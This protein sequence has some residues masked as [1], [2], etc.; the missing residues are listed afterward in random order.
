[1]RN[2][3]SNARENVIAV[4]AFRDKPERRNAKCVQVNSVFKSVNSE[5]NFRRVSL[6]STLS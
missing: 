1:M 6:D 5:N 3:F 2:L 4:F